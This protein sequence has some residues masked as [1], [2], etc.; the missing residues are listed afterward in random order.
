MHSLP[1]AD[2]NWRKFQWAGQPQKPLYAIVDEA[3]QKP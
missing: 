3:K 1:L 2:T